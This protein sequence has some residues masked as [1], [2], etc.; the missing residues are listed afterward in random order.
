[1]KEITFFLINNQIGYWSY[2]LDYLFYFIFPN[3]FAFQSV[4]IVL[5]QRQK[6]ALEVMRRMKIE[7]YRRWSHKE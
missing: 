4:Q 3:G 6:D 5:Q 1:M 7:I 2:H